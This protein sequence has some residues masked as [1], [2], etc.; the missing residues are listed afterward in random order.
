VTSPFNDDEI[1][2]AEEAVRRAA[3]AVETAL[4]DRFEVAMNTY[5]R[6][7]TADEL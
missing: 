3:D 6:P 4:S 1:E 2:V 7:P 5:N